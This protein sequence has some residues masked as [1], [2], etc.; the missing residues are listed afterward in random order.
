MVEGSNRNTG[1]VL[2]TQPTYTCTGPVCPL[3]TPPLSNNKV[4]TAVITALP[5]SLMPGHRFELTPSRYMHT[6]LHHWYCKHANKI[7]QTQSQTLACLELH[8]QGLEISQSVRLD[9]DLAP[10]PPSLR[11]L[12]LIHI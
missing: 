2:S 9:L 10:H 8:W 6:F 5:R 1:S 12:S 7:V 3:L 11:P 4:K